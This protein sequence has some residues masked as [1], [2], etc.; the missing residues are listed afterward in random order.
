MDEAHALWSQAIEEAGLSWKY[1]QV[2]HAC[3][4]ATPCGRRELSREPSERKLSADV[5][6][7]PGQVEGG[8]WDVM[9]KLGDAN[10]RKQGGG[11]KGRVDR[12]KFKDERLDAPLPWDHINTGISK[13]WLK[14]DLQRALEAA[15]VPDCSHSGLCSEC[16]VCGD[17]F[18]DNVVAEVSAHAP[19]A[20]SRPPTS[21]RCPPDPHQSPPAAYTSHRP[22]AEAKP[23]Q[24]SEVG[25][26]FGV[27][28]NPRDN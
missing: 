21:A 12:G 28:E 25:R 19:L 20:T 1:R 16:G 4:G 7:S 15:T 13:E 23:N 10:Y 9:E 11:G 5:C 26:R 27:D 3:R 22:N 2:R 18:G 6:G 17:D 14:T 8:N 24:G